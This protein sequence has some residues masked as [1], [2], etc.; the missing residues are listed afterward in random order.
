MITLKQRRPVSRQT[1]QSLQRGRASKKGVERANGQSAS[2]ASRPRCPSGPDSAMVRVMEHRGFER[3]P[4][5]CGHFRRRA[6]SIP[7]RHQSGHQT[8]SASSNAYS[9]SDEFQPMCVLYMGVRWW[10]VQLNPCGRPKRSRRT[11]SIAS[12][13]AW[14]WTRR[15]CSCCSCRVRVGSQR[16]VGMSISPRGCGPH[17]RHSIERSC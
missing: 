15:W 13:S 3:L 14:P 5:T 7:S 4:A 1:T 2:V 12:T 10:A 11:H 16:P 17:G 8:L 6:G 9:A